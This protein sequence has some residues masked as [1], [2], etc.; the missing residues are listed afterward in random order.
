[1]T[2]LQALLLGIIQ[3]LTEFL[4]I[5][6]TA[7]LTIAGTFLGL[8]NPA[9]PGDWTAF[10]AIIQLGTVAAVITY[11][12]PDLMEMV[13]SVNA[14]I[15]KKD[16]RPHW[17]HNSRLA[18][19]IIVG[20]IPVVV[21][22]LAL[23]KIIEGTL[24][25]SPTVIATSM[26]VLALILLWAERTG[27]R[28]RGETHT[29]WKDALVV[30]IAQAFALIPGSSRSGT[31]ITA[32]LVLGFT[33]DT[34]AR[35]SFLLSIPAVLASGLYELYGIRHQYSEL[36]LAPLCVATLAS[37]IVGY[38]TIAFLLR[39]LKTHSTFLFIYYRLIAGCILFGLVAAT[40]I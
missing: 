2:L 39:Y 35:F 9:R 40:L 6:S 24:T 3:G 13:R 29:S 26:I 7:H 10:I 25:K 36:S 21:A 33:R 32:A 28:D 8:I 30:G 15:R 14:D 11:F 22:G 34:A 38:L 17:S 5:S 4:P 20:T 12:F 19:Q 18:G 31:T 27:R 37:G 1:M 16:N 23:K